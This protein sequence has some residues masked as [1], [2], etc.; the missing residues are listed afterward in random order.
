MNIRNMYIVSDV[1]V[2]V[3]IRD[4]EPALIQIKALEVL[5]Q[6]FCMAWFLCIAPGKD[7]RWSFFAPS[8]RSVYSHNRRH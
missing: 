5:E 7:D 3:Y 2:P 4:Q 8:K 1:T 6:K